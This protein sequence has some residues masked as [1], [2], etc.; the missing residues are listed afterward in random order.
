MR[1]G[2]E[3]GRDNITFNGLS[4]PEF[5]RNLADIVERGEDQQ[6]PDIFL[7]SAELEISDTE[8]YARIILEFIDNHSLETKVK[9]NDPPDRINIDI[10]LK[11]I[12]VVD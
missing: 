5:L 8:H 12:E 7:N 1:V 11:D 4:C 10:A 3:V 6:I 2:I 9:T